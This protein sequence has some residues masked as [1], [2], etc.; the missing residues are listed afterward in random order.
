[1]EDH[2]LETNLVHQYRGYYSFTYQT[3]NSIEPVRHS[4]HAGVV[5][6]DISLHLRGRIMHRRLTVVPVQCILLIMEYI[7]C[8]QL[9]ARG[10]QG[11]ES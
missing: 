9:L 7:A 10:Q 2:M 4:M 3:G 5:L 8:Q 11:F 6:Q 1:M